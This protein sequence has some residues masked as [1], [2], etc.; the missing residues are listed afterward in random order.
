VGTVTAFSSPNLTTGGETKTQDQVGIADT[1]AAGQFVLTASPSS[2]SMQAALSDAAAN[3]GGWVNLDVYAVSGNR[4]V[5]SSIARKLSSNVWLSNN[6]GPPSTTDA[7]MT[8]KMAPGTSGFVQ[9]PRSSGT[10]RTQALGPICVPQTTVLSNANANAIVG[11]MHT[12][13]NMTGWFSYGRKADTDFGVGFSRDGSQWSVT[14]SAHVA[15]TNSAAVRWDV[16]SEFGYRLLSNFAF[17]KTKTVCLGFAAVPPTYK[18][19]VKR[20]NGGAVIG[21][22]VHYLDHK[23]LTTYSAYKV[24]QGPNTTFDRTS[25]SAVNYSAGVTIFGIQLSA[26]SGY[27]TDVAA[28]WA[29]GGRFTA[30]WLCGTD[31]PPT[32][33]HTVLAGG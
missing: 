12:G 9:L 8:F 26:K 19:K 15:T 32:I 24:Q 25:S 14:G 4:M 10:R 18:I 16:G 7:R 21:D 5:Y 23:C 11:N 28:H 31:G 20:W 13:T 17:Q 30:Y 3:N 29:M 2:A 27:S 1:D 22:N 6:P 33:A